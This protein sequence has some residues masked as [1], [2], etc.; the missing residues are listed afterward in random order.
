MNIRQIPQI[1]L[2][3]LVLLVTGCAET[4]APRDFAFVNVTQTPR[5]W[6]SPPETPRYR[7]VGELTGEKNFI[8]KP[9]EKSGNIANRFFKW[10]V[11][12]G[13]SKQ[14]PNILQGPQSG[15]VD[16]EGRIYVTDIS[17]NAVFV[18]DKPGGKLQV[19]DM[20]RNGTPFKTPIGI[21]QGKQIDRGTQSE[22]LV[23][24]ADLRSV[25]RLNQKGELLGEFGQDVLQRP[26]GL[27]R[28]AQRGLI[29]VADTH[30]HDIKVF[31]DD[32]TLQRVI[33]KRGEGDG[34]F[35]FPTFLAFADGRLYVTDT[36]NTRIQIFDTDGKMIAK[37]GQRGMKVGNLVRPKGVAV[38]SEHNIYVIESQYDNLLVFNNAGRPLMALGGQGI[39]IGQ[40]YQPSGVWVDS[41]DQVYIA[42]LL[43]GRIL[44]LQFLGGS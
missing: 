31:G 41:H 12:L 33:G 26:T 30:G 6:P 10:L 43:N 9:Q 23:A 4:Q 32:G 2:L 27:A 16:A 40:F 25:F 42:D 37:F 15:M 28:D 38:D 17:R 39:E 5:V 7:Y 1:A 24:D 18:F 13:S 22:I 29:Y 36:M 8:E 44:V 19:W 34:E 11:G 14:K 35:N 3:G 20:A 21:A